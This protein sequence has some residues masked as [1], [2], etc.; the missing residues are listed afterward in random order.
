MV[1]MDD[2]IV[3]VV[4]TVVG[5]LTALTTYLVAT[6]RYRWGRNMS[7][8]FAFSLAMIT[9]FIATILAVISVWGGCGDTR[10]YLMLDS[11]ETNVKG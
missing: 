1:L 2:I 10:F 8:S 6:Q 5:V 9:G 11:Y 4:G 7:L 3:L